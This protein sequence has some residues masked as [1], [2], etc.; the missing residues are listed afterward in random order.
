MP[1]AMRVRRAVWPGDVTGVHRARAAAGG[2]GHCRGAGDA[3]R[4]QHG[5]G[6]G[7]HAGVLHG[8]R[9]RRRDRSGDGRRARPRAHA[10]PMAGCRRCSCGCAA[11]GC[12]GIRPDS[13]PS[14]TG[15]SRSS[16]TS[17]AAAARR[18][19]APASPTR[20]SARA[21]TSPGA[22]RKPTT[23]RW[24]RTN[25]KTCRRSRSS[26][27]R[28]S[29]RPRCRGWCS[30]ICAAR[31]CSA[32]GHRLPPA[33]ADA[34]LDGLG[35]DELAL[36]YEQLPRND[37]ASAARDRTARAASPARRACRF[38]STSPPIPSSCW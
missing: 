8:A 28:S 33:L 29:R 26:C 15:G 7:V 2:C 22:W 19:S 36:R 4:D 21:A 10:G 12:G 11:G 25:A 20:W 24:R 3:G 17:R 18:F 6:G 23:I 5:D 30:G 9:A 37:L 35:R 13:A 1:M 31:S 16:P 38:V 27:R 32:T 14:S 34:P